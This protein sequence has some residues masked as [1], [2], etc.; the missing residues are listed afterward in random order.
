[1]TFRQWTGVRRGL[2]PWA[3]QLRV[4]IGERLLAGVWQL[5]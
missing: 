5:R 1:M 4:G 3:R 2:V